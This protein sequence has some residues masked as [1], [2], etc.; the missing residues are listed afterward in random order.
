ME[1]NSDIIIP[2]PEKTYELPETIEKK[3]KN[4]CKWVL[5]PKKMQHLLKS[6]DFQFWGP[7]LP[8]ESTSCAILFF[9]LL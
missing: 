3:E 4:Y 7:F 8:Q 9:L 1:W 2:V 6:T 5:K